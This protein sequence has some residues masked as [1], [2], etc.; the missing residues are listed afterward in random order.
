[1]KRK[2]TLEIAILALIIIVFG[3]VLLI[4]HRNNSGLQD[5]SGLRQ[6]KSW[7]PHGVCQSIN[8]PA[9]GSC[10]ESIVINNKCYVKKGDYSQYY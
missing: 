2:Q 1:V 4:R 5:T 8:D 7:N 3:A 10:P 6:V 9:C